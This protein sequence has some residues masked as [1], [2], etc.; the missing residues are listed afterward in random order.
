[1]KSKKGILPKLIPLI[2]SLLAYGALPIVGLLTAPLLARALG[3]EGRGELAAVLQPLILASAVA[4]LGLPSAVTYFVGRAYS[5]TSVA[6]FSY[7]LAAITTTAVTI[8]LVWYSGVISQS[9]G[10]SR[11][12]I[13]LIWSAFIPSAFIAVR[14]ACFQGLLDYKTID[15]ERFASTLLRLLLIVMLTL[16]AVGLASAFAAAFMISGLLASLVLLRK[17][18]YPRN[19]A[20]QATPKFAAILRFSSMVSFGTIAAA[21]N[22]RLDQALMPSAVSTSE[23]GFYAV[24]VSIAEIPTVITMVVVRNALAEASSGE[25]SRIKFTIVAGAGLMGLACLSIAVLASPAIRIFFGDQF[26]PTVAIAQIL[27]LSVFVAFFS[28]TITAVLAGKGHPGLASAGP[29]AGALTT[30]LLFASEWQNLSAQ[31]VAQISVMSQSAAV[32]VGACGLV[33]TANANRRVRRD[34]PLS[35]RMEDK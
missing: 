26:A 17:P 14:R 18:K 5:V 4:A 12:T 19:Y 35:M 31:R 29:F 32:L 7:Q 15:F 30:I 9:T 25:G 28:D 20:E 13:L 3:P 33:L 2:R 27:L 21:M 23:L 1:M 10:I 34:A 8:P 11:W 6:K 24:A 22:S 16:L